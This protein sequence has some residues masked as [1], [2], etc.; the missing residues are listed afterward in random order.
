MD[1]IFYHLSYSIFDWTYDRISD[2]MTYHILSLT[3]HEIGYNILSLIL[4]HVIS[5]QPN[6]TLR[7]SVFNVG[8]DENFEIFTRFWQ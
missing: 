3:K 7:V 6:M 4:S 5:D 2:K 1:N 8:I